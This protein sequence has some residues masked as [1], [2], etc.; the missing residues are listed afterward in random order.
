MD[1]AEDERAI[2]DEFLRRCPLK[3]DFEDHERRMDRLGRKALKLGLSVQAAEEYRFIVSD[4]VKSRWLGEWFK[5]RKSQHDARLEYE[6][7]H[8]EPV[9]IECPPPSNEEVLERMNQS[10]AMALLEHQTALICD[11]DCPLMPYDRNYRCPHL[12]KM[13]KDKELSQVENAVLRS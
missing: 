6:R 8:P 3:F 7:T 5:Y 4:L 2:L 1:S 11:C 12:V 9:R 13:L 10:C